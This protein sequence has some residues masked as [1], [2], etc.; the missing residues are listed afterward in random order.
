MYFRIP[1]VPQAKQRPQFGNGKTFTP[2]RTKDAEAEIAKEVWAR[3]TSLERKTCPVS[4]PVSLEVVFHM[5]I[6]KSLSKT[7][8]TAMLGEPHTQRPDLDNLV[9]IFDA[10]N[11]LIWKDDTQIWKIHA[12]KRWAREG[13]IEI[14]VT[15]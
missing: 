11:G 12:E 2:Q 1:V 15:I 8:Q 3:M 14:N 4:V 13:A 5:P 9:K 10:L 6:A 7:K